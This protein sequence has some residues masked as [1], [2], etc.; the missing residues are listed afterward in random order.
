[1]K[2]LISLLIALFLL[3]GVKANVTM[4]RIFSDNMVLQR[5]KPIPVWGWAK[6]GETVWV[7]LNKQKKSVKADKNGNWRLNLSTENAGGPYTLSVRSGNVVTFSNVLVGEVWICSGQSNM[8]WL[9][10]SANNAEEELMV[11]DYPEI[12]NFNVPKSINT[13]LQNDMKSGN[14]EMCT[15]K[16][17]RNF[18]AVG[19]FFARKLY[20][21]LNIPIGLIHTSWGGTEI[22]T[23]TSGTALQQ[24]DEFKNV[25]SAMPALNLDSVNRI[26]D[27]QLHKDFLVW[28][29][30]LLEPELMDTWHKPDIDDSKWSKLM[31]PAAWEKQG[32]YAVDGKLVFRKSFTVKKDEAGKAAILELGKVD[33]NDVT[34][35]N[36]FKVGATDGFNIH[37]KY[38][39]PPGILKEG[40]NVVA[41]QVEDNV[42]GGGFHGDKGMK[43]N[44]GKREESIAGLWSYKI[45]SLTDANLS[46]ILDPNQFPTLLFNAMV[47]PLISFGIQGVIWY[48]GESNTKRA[49]QYRQAFPLMIN[50][51]RKHWNQG[52]FPFYFV[53]LASYNAG[54][55]ADKNAGY[56]WAELR[57]AQTMTLSLPNTGMAVTTDIGNPA[58]IH[59][60]NKQNVGLR[61]ALLALDKTYKKALVSNGP[62]FKSM[63]IEGNKLILSYSNTGS[64]LMT[65]DKFGY[66]KGFEIAGADR[67][68]VYAKAYIKGSEV[69]V[70]SDDVTSPVAVRFGWFDDA[71]ENN[72]FNKEGL[73]ASPFT[74]DTWDRVTANEKYQI[75]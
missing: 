50:D 35:I 3:P 7:Q 23:W 67:T 27:I 1:M 49:V 12:R 65:T 53:Q 56:E 44:F 59:P 2:Q 5:N 24:S 28:Q 43:I 51:W 36:G 57:E 54:G 62:M 14:W 8:E 25:M 45:L 64:G 16:N 19:Y 4:P 37:R 21:E 41:V 40:K 6:S 66:V 13:V 38:I 15:P 70:Y 47:N 9:L 69:V 75:R 18:S 11:A 31:E 10:Q 39:I 22:E 34:Y 72:L 33:D 52:D 58:D 68:F 60:R 17:A 29:K 30:E 48:Q 32:L 46:S 63:K 26:K 74:T 55:T 61:L 42:G 73:P 20:Q 71:S